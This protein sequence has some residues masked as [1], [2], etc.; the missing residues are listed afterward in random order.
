MISLV[1]LLAFGTITFVEQDIDLYGV[2]GHDGRYHYGLPSTT[3]RLADLDGNGE[4]D[5]VLPLT[6]AF[7]RDGSFSKSG[8]TRLPAFSE[9]PQ[10]DIWGNLLY[11]LFPDRMEVVR[12]TETGWQA[13]LSQPVAWPAPL[14]EKMPDAPEEGRSYPV[15][16][17]RFLYDLDQDEQPE[18]VRAA[19]DAV[20]VFAKKDLFYE[21]AARWD[22]YP[23]NRIRPSAPSNLWP[24]GVRVLV[25]PSESMWCRLQIDRR[26][27]TVWRTSY[28]DGTTQK[29]SRRQYPFHREQPFELDH[30]RVQESTQEPVP[31]QYRRYVLNEDEALDY[32]YVGKGGETSGP[33]P[34]PTI[35]TVASADGG[36]SFT[37]VQSDGIRRPEFPFVDYNGDGRLD[38]VT[39][40]KMLMEGGIRE[41]LLRGLTRRKVEVTIEIR[42]QDENGKFSD[43]ADL[44]ASFSIELDRPPV[45]QSNMFESFLSGELVK[46]TGDFTGDG[47]VD[48]AIM[49]RPDRIAVYEG[50]TNSFSKP[51]ISTLQVLRDSKFFVADADGDNRADLIVKTVE[52]LRSGV[53][54]TARVFLT[55]AES[56]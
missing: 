29:D 36:K 54:P 16:F 7:Q 26:G 35:K 15:Q 13:I 53:P 39:D 52:N 47:I 31:A 40:S 22:I 27:V 25:P 48:A 4:S 17:D 46:L 18:I 11:F 56:Q 49:D 21:Q 55:R 14:N 32:F 44:R 12:W 3:F 37:E 20:H 5:L 42:L 23:P 34:V 24:A 30:T 50:Q 33:L 9:A 6:V 10:C 38:L 2:F 28:I 43:S 1:P 19:L 51:P 45:S 41:T 8:Q